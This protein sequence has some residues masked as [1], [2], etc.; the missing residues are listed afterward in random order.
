MDHLDPHLAPSH[1]PCVDVI[2][3]SLLRAKVKTE[4]NHY[5]FFAYKVGFHPTR[6]KGKKKEL[7]SYCPA[8]KIQ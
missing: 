6:I 8:L 3:S 2:A 7:S 4:E 5:L 1:G